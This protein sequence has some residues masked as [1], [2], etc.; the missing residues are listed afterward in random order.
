LGDHG[1]V[2]GQPPWLYEELLHL[3]FLIHLPGSAEA[4][5]RVRQLTQTV[6]LGP[7]LID[8][9]GQPAAPTAHGRSLLPLTRGEPKRIRDFACSC[10]RYGG[11]E[12]WSLRTQEWC[13]LLPVTNPGTPVR[14]ARKT[15]PQLYIKPDDRW[16]VNDVYSQHTDVADHLELGLR[17][18]AA[19]VRADR[20]NELPD[21]VLPSTKR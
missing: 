4:G 11:E 20:L 3:P 21:L 19:A 17:R 10:A 8:A 14:P 12:A 9:F 2:G 7:T 13:L 15:N 5:R 1:L 16:E 18:F 6:D